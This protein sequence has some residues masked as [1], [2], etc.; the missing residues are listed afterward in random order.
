[1]YRL[2]VIACSAYEVGLRSMLL[3]SL[4]SPENCILGSIAAA[5]IHVSFTLFL[6]SET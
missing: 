4:L 3:A 1:M 2:V 5:N 6:N